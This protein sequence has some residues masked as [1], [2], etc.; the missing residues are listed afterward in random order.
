MS[1]KINQGS[2]ALVHIFVNVIRQ[3]S[4]YLCWEYW[5]IFWKC[6]LS[7]RWG[8]YQ[9]LCALSS[10][11]WLAAVGFA[12]TRSGSDDCGG[13]GRA[14]GFVVLPLSFILF[15][16]FSLISVLTDM[17]NVKWSLLC[18][19]LPAALKTAPAEGVLWLDCSVVA[20]STAWSGAVGKHT[21]WSVSSEHPASL[22]N[23]AGSK[24]EHN[25]TG[26]WCTLG[27]PHQVLT[28]AW[29]SEWIWDKLNLLSS[30]NICQ[31][32]PTKLPRVY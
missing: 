25:N 18:S 28:D 5:E 7:Y 17:R 26:V 8:L 4:I 13:W 20:Y 22:C 9:V 30:T 3:A 10:S 1:C 29:L 11:F 27:L 12:D 16:P 32:K 24:V 19:F 23:S 15:C 2:S 14:L 6:C 21:N 31:L